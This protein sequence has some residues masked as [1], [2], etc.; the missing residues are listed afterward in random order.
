[1]DGV[2]LPQG[3]RDTTRGQVFTNKFPEIAGTHFIGF[4]GI[5]SPGGF[6]HGT[7]ELGIKRLNR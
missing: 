5:E 3:Y 2:Q 7:L 6:E 4:G 1:M